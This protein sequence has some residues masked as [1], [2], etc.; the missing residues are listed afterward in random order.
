MVYSLGTVALVDICAITVIGNSTVRDPQV[1][2]WAVNV[3][4]RG[5]VKEEPWQRPYGVT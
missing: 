3:N 4:K 2:S 5:I 1:T